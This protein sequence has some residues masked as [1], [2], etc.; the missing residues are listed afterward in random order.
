MM[1]QTD[2]G[3]EGCRMDEFAG[4]VMVVHMD[5][6]DRLVEGLLNIYFLDSVYYPM[7]ICLKIKS[8]EFHARSS[9]DLFRK[10]DS[11]HVSHPELHNSQLVQQVH[12]KCPTSTRIL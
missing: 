9:S 1:V 7:N 12:Q 5:R 3:I 11:G 8:S 10:S 2:L 6:Y 4:T